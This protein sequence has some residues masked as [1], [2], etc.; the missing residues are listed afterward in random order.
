M[1]LPS[2]HLP[3]AF[4]VQ[5]ISVYSLPPLQTFSTITIDQPNIHFYEICDVPNIFRSFIRL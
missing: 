4:P 2:P 1:F 5:Y 3:K